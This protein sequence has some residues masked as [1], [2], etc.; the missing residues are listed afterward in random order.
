MH[1]DKTMFGGNVEATVLLVEPHR[2]LA[3][4]LKGWLEERGFEVTPASDAAAA[5]ALV[6]RAGQFA[7]GFDGLLV[8]LKLPDAMSY[9]VVTAFRE[10]FPEHPV[11]VMTAGESIYVTLWAKAHNILILRKPFGMQDLTTWCTSVKATLM[12]V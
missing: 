4:A 8:S 10:K 7:S 12:H 1:I 9:R 3:E 5:A 11:A 2:P 6:A